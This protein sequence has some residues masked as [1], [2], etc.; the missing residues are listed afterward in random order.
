MVQD[1]P[2]YREH[3]VLDPGVTEEELE[4]ESEGYL[5]DSEREDQGQ[6]E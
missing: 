1:H 4:A 2:E 3:K 5:E 6:L